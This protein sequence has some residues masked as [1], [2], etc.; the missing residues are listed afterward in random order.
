MITMK[1]EIGKS[2]HRFYSVW[3]GEVKIGI[4]SRLTYGGKPSNTWT[5]DAVDGKSNMHAGKTPEQ[6]ARA[7]SKHYKI[8]AETQR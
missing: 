3:N 2:G 5:Y 7:L 8:V 6:A 4:V 1:P